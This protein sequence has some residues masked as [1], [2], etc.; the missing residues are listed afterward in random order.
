MF[1]SPLGM[2]W[3]QLDPMVDEKMCLF[4]RIP[5]VQWWVSLS[6]FRPP[7]VLPMLRK[8]RGETAGKLWET[9]EIQG[10]LDWFRDV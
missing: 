1:F 3:S 9:V 4:F 10:S 2:E 6:P 8:E 7:G 5:P